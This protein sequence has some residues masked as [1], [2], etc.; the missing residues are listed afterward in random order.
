M[1]PTET[2][3]TLTRGTETMKDRYVIRRT[4]NR[5]GDYDHLT[6]MSGNCP[7]WCIPLQF[8]LVMD[9]DEAQATLDLIG[10]YRD[11]F[12][13]DGITGCAIV[14]FPAVAVIEVAA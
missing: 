14:P 10:T 1:T 5:H 12:A 13:P 8:A 7:T 4:Y 6:H 2:A 11:A 9:M 3:G